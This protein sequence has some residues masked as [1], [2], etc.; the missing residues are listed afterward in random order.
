MSIDISENSAIYQAM[1][2]TIVIR[3]KLSLRIKKIYFESPPKNVSINRI[4]KSAFSKIRLRY[5]NRIETYGLTYDKLEYSDFRRLNVKH[6]K[7]I[8]NQNKR[9]LSGNAEIYPLTFVCD[10]CSD[11]VSLRDDDL[12]TFDPDRCEAK[13]CNGKYKQV[14]VLKYCET[15]G[16]IEPLYYKCEKN[17]SHRV[18]LIRPNKTY[19]KGWYFHCPTCN[20]YSDIINPHLCYHKEQYTGKLIS[21]KEPKRFGLITLLQQ[22]AFSPLIFSMVQLP[23]IN[24]P[25]SIK[26]SSEID[27][28]TLLVAIVRGDFDE[29]TDDY[30]MDDSIDL[31]KDIISE[32][33][34]NMRRNKFKR[35]LKR[36]NLEISEEEFEEQWREESGIAE[37]IE[38]H[39]HIKDCYTSFNKQAILEYAAI[40]GVFSGNETLDLEEYI[41]SN[42][43]ERNDPLNNMMNNMHI[44]SIK[45]VPKIMI[46]EVCYG[47]IRGYSRQMDDTFT[48]QFDPLWNDE[49]NRDDLSTYVHSYKTEGLVIKLDRDK[50]HQWL[51]DNGAEFDDDEKKPLTKQ[52]FTINGRNFSTKILLHTI[53]HSLINTVDIFT[54]ISPQNCGEIIFENELT[55]FLFHRGGINVGSMRYVFENDIIDWI[56]KSFQE[57]IDCKMDPECALKSGACFSCLFLPEFVCNNF[58]NKLDRNLIIGNSEKMMKGFWNG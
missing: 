14:I 3:N 55:I 57:I 17:K 6:I 12:E 2:G 34:N 26:E 31:I 23:E 53:S 52:E 32:Y 33:N 56:E 15:C 42:K 40:T 9:D 38:I 5:N 24:I 48:P 8:Q 58:N 1:V 46:S 37:I 27:L 18:K 22:N 16:K 54:G 44:E 29:L 13:G 7:F 30:E 35:K 41:S 11:F 20:R 4:A 43:P 36:E 47:L 19:P 21:T 49:F 25:E 50:V 28:D 10:R 45:Y 51:I 39:D